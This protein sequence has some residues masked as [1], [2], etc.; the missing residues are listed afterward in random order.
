M[1][2]FEL[3][4]HVFNK[5]PGAM[6]FVSNQGFRTKKP[7]SAKTYGA[8][9]YI[10][11]GCHETQF[12]IS[13]LVEKACIN[14]FDTSEHILELRSEPEHF[15]DILDQIKKVAKLAY[16][17][18]P[19]SSSEFSSF[20]DFWAVCRTPQ[21]NTF[22][23]CAP[24]WDK[25][26]RSKMHIN[27]FNDKTS[28]EMTGVVDLPEGARI[29]AAVRC[30]F[31]ED[32]DERGFSVGVR[33][34]FGAGLRILDLGHPPPTIRA[35]WA[36][37][38]VD[39]ATL[40]VPLYSTF[41]VKAP[42]MTVTRVEGQCIHVDARAKPAFQKAINALHALAD[43]PEWDSTIVIDSDRPP[44]HTQGLII[45]MI[46]PSIRDNGI[47]WHT[48]SFR[49]SRRKARVV[50]NHAARVLNDAHVA[51]LAAN[52]VSAAGAAEEE[53]AAEEAAAEEAAAEVSVSVEEVGASFGAQS[54]GAKRERDSKDNSF[55][56]QTKRQCT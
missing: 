9:T 17:Q 21:N 1:N 45:A 13:G 2:I 12:M 4:E 19:R 6:E 23:L 7:A 41:R 40:S 42:A 32:Q 15:E 46:S 33:L 31:C 48:S 11:S 38:E 30:T 8:T 51:G 5:L 14:N 26:R 50:R 49:V 43:V 34:R 27:L 24:S 35:P 18:L 20:E 36:W 54:P 22:R 55:G 37:D 44:V 28:D 52:G 16:A 10:F 25:R 47:V 29:Q 39:P 56:V 3:K 53:A